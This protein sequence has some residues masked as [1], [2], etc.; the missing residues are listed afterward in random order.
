MQGT[1]PLQSQDHANPR[2][3]GEAPV[4]PAPPRGQRPRTGPPFPSFSP[5]SRPGADLLPGPAGSPARSLAGHSLG[6]RKAGLA[7]AR[8]HTPTPGSATD[9]DQSQHLP[10]PPPSPKP[11]RLLS[12]G[13][14]ICLFKTLPVFNCLRGRQRWAVSASRAHFPIKEAGLS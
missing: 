8:T 4:L 9:S 2:E 6:C 7:E 1:F 10:W 14:N 13:S 11:P 3:A 5:A 12:N